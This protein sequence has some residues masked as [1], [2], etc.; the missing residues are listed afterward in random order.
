M[1]K[2]IGLY[3]FVRFYLKKKVFVTLVLPNYYLITFEFKV[4][5]GR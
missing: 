1:I 2:K 5:T 3:I 4:N